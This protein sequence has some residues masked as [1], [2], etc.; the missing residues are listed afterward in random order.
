MDWQQPAALL[1]VAA[2]VIV[3]IRR[4]L[5]KVGKPCPGNCSCPGDRTM[6]KEHHRALEK[7]ARVSYL[8]KD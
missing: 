4:S 3:L 2:A 1:V 8:K 5:R 7:P 6:P